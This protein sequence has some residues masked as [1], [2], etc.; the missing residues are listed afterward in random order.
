MSHRQVWARV[1][2]PVD[3]GARGLVEALSAF[4][5]LQTIESCQ[6]PPVWVCFHVGYDPGAWEAP[7]RLVLGTIGPALM[8]AV[9][10]GAEVSMRVTQVGFVQGELTVHPD[11]LDDTV[12]LLHTLAAGGG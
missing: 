3:E 10:D 9:G 11:V 4:E 7:C 8:R 2:A 12:S 6:G 5:G 1:N